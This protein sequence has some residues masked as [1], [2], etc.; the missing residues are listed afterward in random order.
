MKTASRSLAWSS[1]SPRWLPA[2]LFHCVCVTHL[3]HVSTGVK[4][5]HCT[6]HGGTLS[7]PTSARSTQGWGHGEENQAI[8]LLLVLKTKFN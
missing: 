5:Q 3:L 6:G 8:K 1:R 4:E 2:G 7:F